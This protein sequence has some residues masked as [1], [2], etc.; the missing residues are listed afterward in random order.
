[1]WGE[2]NIGFRGRNPTYKD[3]EDH[4][5]AAITVGRGAVLGEVIENKKNLD[6]PRGIQ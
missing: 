1:M 2:V 3:H 5:I 4:G 6:K